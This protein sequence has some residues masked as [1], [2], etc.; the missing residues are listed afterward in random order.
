[1][2]KNMSVA[3]FNIREHKAFVC[4]DVSMPVI[5]VQEILQNL[6]HFC[7]ERLKEAEAEEAQRLA[8]EKASAPIEVSSE[9]VEVVAEP[10][11][12]VESEAIV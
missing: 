4:L 3:E 8:D 1:M 9:S 6:M 5:V 10:M 12:G 7:V 2:F 11:P